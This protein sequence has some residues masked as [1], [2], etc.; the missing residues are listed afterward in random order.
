MGSRGFEVLFYFL[1]LS[2]TKRIFFSIYVYWPVESKSDVHFRLQKP[3][4]LYGLENKLPDYLGFPIRP[5]EM[6]TEFRFYRSKTPSDCL[7]NPVNSRYP[8]NSELIFQNVCNYRN[9]EKLKNIQNGFFL[10]SR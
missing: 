6:D 1:F 5:T 8:E 7:F 2:S 4:N 9:K 3:E 10:N